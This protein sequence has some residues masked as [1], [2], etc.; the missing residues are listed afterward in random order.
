MSLQ[1]FLI[2][3]PFKTGIY[4]YLKPW[5]SP[6]DAFNPLEDAYVYRGVLQKRKGYEEIGSRFTDYSARLMNKG[7]EYKTSTGTD[8]YTGTL[9]NTPIRP[10]SI[11]I[12][13]EK[14][15]P[16]TMTVTDDGS[17][18]LI[19]DIGAGTNTIDYETGA[20]NVTFEANTTREIV[21]Y[22]VYTPTASAVMMINEHINSS[23]NAKS[24]VV[25]DQK[26][27]C[28]YNGTTHQFDPVYQIKISFDKLLVQSTTY[29]INTGFTNLAHFSVTVT[30]GGESSTDD[31]I[32][33]IAA[34]ATY[35]ALSSVVYAT[36]VITLVTQAFGATAKEGSY[37]AE[38]ATDYF[39]GSTEEYF[40]KINW[41]DVLYMTN[42]KD[43]ITTFDGTYI[44]RPPLAI[45]LSQYNALTNAVD[46]ALDVNVY[47][48]RLLLMR[49]TESNIV[50]PYTIRFTKVN[51]PQNFVSDQ[52]GNGGYTNAPTSDW[53]MGARFLKDTLVCKFERSDYNFIY[54]GNPFEPFTFQKVSD[55]RSTEAPYAL[56]AFDT[57]VT[58]AGKRGLVK[59]DG[60]NIQ[61]YDE[62]I[63]D[64]FNTLI[65]QSKFNICFSKR[66]DALQQM[67][68]LYPDGLE[69]ASTNN[70]VLVWN[71]AEDT[72]S[73]Y[74]M[75]FS[76]LGNG[77]ITSDEKWDNINE[78]WD[79]LDIP[80]DYYLRQAEGITI[81]AGDYN[82]KVYEIGG[83]GNDN[84]TSYNFDITSSEWNPF[85][86]N[87]TKINIPYIDLFYTVDQSAE[88]TIDFMTD[89]SSLPSITKKV[90]LDGNAHNTANWTRI[91]INLTGQ[92]IKLRMYL[93][94]DQL[95][96]S[97]IADNIIYIHGFI[98][99]GREAGRLI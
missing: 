41:N 82:G 86:R 39:S 22:Y 48:N 87:G 75:N 81:Y 62:K 76:C 59:S 79:E 49:T 10:S 88:M 43:R 99:Y 90:T 69:N 15:G 53:Y 30:V 93:S 46:T 28:V 97:T 27:S 42:N 60:V 8:T 34:T 17:G 83:I 9:T 31:G 29:T 32:G 7:I 71:Y 78:P 98:L 36:G 64:I 26:R 4:R 5:L 35:I 47:K 21:I 73:I 37:T 23:D 11:V 72:W 6:E 3:S 68:M 51:V 19:G 40:N 95:S 24:L 67:W 54:S 66:Y 44:G 74:N 52:T 65:N 2:G 92:F 16:T 70:R 91:F 85:S 1:P 61:R 14:A 84:G 25:N 38:T 18:N 94:D 77:E 55:S 56:E 45:T 58:S 57:F 89:T 33:G 96:D 50:Q 13:S 63:I 12:V 20:Y 80:W